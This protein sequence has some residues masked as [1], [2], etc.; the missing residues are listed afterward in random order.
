MTALD[1]AAGA[2]TGLRRRAGE[3][4]LT[5]EVI[6][7]DLFE[8]S[9]KWD[10][11]FN[12]LG[13]H[14]CFCAIPLHRRSDYVRVA[15]RVLRSDASLVSLFFEVDV[16]MEDG[17]PFPTTRADVVGHFEPAFEIHAIRTAAGLLCRAPGTGVVGTHATHLILLRRL[18]NPPIPP[19]LFREQATLEIPDCCGLR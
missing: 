15:A 8:L 1:L 7:A 17:P 14:T 5:I 9:G 11:T 3:E 19:F 16:P 12:L 2:V 4:G 6:Q 18:C 10:D 13:E